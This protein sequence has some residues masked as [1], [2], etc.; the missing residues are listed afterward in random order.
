MLTHSNVVSLP[1][2][3]LT[4]FF[5]PSVVDRI[6]RSVWN[7][8]IPFHPWSIPIAVNYVV[9]SIILLM[10]DDLRGIAVR[11]VL[12]YRKEFEIN[13]CFFLWMDTPAWLAVLVFHLL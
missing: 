3:V 1:Q 2:S 9:A 6:G 8:V 10:E 4:T 11:R 13:M 5:N 7:Y 12:T